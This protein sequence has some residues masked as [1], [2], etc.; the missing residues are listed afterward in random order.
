ME[1]KAGGGGLGKGNKR[2]GAPAATSRAMHA[3]LAPFQAANKIIR[4]P[5]M[6]ARPGK[7]SMRL[8]QQRG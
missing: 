3:A 2:K 1:A 4:H 5:H 6:H 8:A 7:L